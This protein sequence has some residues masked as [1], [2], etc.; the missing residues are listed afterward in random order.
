[1]RPDLI[2][3]DCDGV[4]IDS[5][6]ISCG[7]DAEILTEAGY[8]ITRDEVVRRFIGRTAD[9]V[10]AEIE[11]DMGRPL[12][13]DL[14]PRI[15][16]RVLELYHTELIAIKGA[17]DFV[18]GLSTRAC[19]ASSSRPS[20]LCLG[21][22][23]TGHFEAFYPDVFSASLVSQGKPAPDIFLFAAARMATD[24]ACCL[25]I[26]DSVAG[27]T[28]ARR[29][30]MPVMG[31]VGGSHCSKGHGDAL[32]EAGAANVFDDFKDLPAMIEAL[33]DTVPSFRVE[34]RR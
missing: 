13:D 17:R 2:I 7:A 18:R 22:I 31:F 3:F 34:A 23:L 6:L 32:I 11:A 20:K 33:P 28:A 16:A 30:G 19:V 1:M 10:R 29:A 5:E 21:L 26:E 4:L 9:S 14:G 15:E 25:V 12:P 24:P 8:P 27:V